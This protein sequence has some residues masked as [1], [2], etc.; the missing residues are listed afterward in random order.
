MPR[1]LQVVTPMAML[2]SREGVGVALISVE[3]WSAGVIVRLAGLPNART[4]VLD[5]EFHGTLDAWARGGREGSPPN[6]PAENVFDVDLALSD[7]SGTSH[8]LRTAS[9]GGSGRM[10]RAEWSFEP[11]PPESPSR[12]SV[13][14][15]REGHQIEVVDLAI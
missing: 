10:F 13:R 15:S 3:V 5:R 14:V 8:M 2:Y 6:Q 12:L 7:D 4:E 1:A 11:G 9:K